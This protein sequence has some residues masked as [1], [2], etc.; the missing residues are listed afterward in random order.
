MNALVKNSNQTRNVTTLEAKAAFQ[1]QK[2]TPGSFSGRLSSP[3]PQRGPDPRK[4]ISL[5][6]WAATSRRSEGAQSGA[7]QVILT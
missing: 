5:A 1:R 3:S 4:R 2:Y 7:E 6:I